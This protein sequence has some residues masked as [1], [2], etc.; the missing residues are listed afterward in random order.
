M[1]YEVITLTGEATRD[2]RVFDADL[3]WHVEGLDLKAEYSQQGV[4]KRDSSVAPDDYTWSAW[5]AQAA[6]SYNF[7]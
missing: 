4:G 3:S 2:Y 5:Y 1:L 7:V 6:Y